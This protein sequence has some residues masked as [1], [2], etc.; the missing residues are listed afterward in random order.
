[1]RIAQVS[2]LFE[3]VPPKAYGGTERI[4]HVL[5]EALVERGHEVTLFASGDSTTSA[6]LRPIGARALRFGGCREPIAPHALM[7]ERLKWEAAAFD[8]IHFHTESMHFNIA[9]VLATPTL[10]T[11]H[12]RQDL[13]EY[14][15]FYREF[16]E[17]PMVSISRSQR[18]PVPHANW[19]GVVHHGIPPENFTFHGGPGSYLAFLGRISYEKR[20]DRAI[21][22]ARRTGWRLKIAAKIDERDEAYVKEVQPR[23]SAPH[24]DFVGEIGEREKSDFLGGAAALLFPIDWPEPFGL[25]M[26]EALAVGTPIIA[27][28]NGSVPEIVRDGVNGFVVDSIEEACEAVANIHL[29]S[30]ARCRRDFEER[31]T[32]DRMAVDYLMIYERLCEKQL[33]GGRFR[34]IG[35]G[36]S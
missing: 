21:E 6:V 29:I 26:I 30:R 33:R 12:G 28:R 22:I 17:L 7:F 15:E 35:G 19:V 31:F 13:T 36:L 16:H 1:M 5:T 8:L 34:R 9:R 14:Q 11:L 23:L 25:V 3:S 20:V 2:P 4:V 18:R 27:F 32:A 24:V 10:T